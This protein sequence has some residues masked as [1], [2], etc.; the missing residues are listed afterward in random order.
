MT[1]RHAEAPTAPHAAATAAT[2]AN[3]RRRL[4]AAPVDTQPRLRPLR[5]AATQ[6]GTMTHAGA[7]TPPAEAAASRHSSRRDDEHRQC[8]L[9][10]R[11]QE[12]EAVG[13]E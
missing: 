11:G 3:P 10:M 8:R 5:R 12:S 6:A 9:P 2:D 1:H 13:W 4:W 7:A